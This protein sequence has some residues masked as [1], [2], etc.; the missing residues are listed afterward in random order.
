MLKVISSLLGLSAWIV[1]NRPF[2]IYTC[3]VCQDESYLRKFF[4]NVSKTYQEIA[5]WKKTKLNFA[6]VLL[7]GF[8]QTFEKKQN[9]IFDEFISSF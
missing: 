8:D 5:Y 1:I 6:L 7:R 9:R 3:A 4:N 2:T